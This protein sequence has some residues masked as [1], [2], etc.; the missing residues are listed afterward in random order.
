[1]KSTQPYLTFSITFQQ[2]IEEPVF[3]ILRTKE[4]LGYHVDCSARNTFGILGYTIKVECQATK[5]TTEYVDERIE[6]FLIHSQTLLEETTEDQLAQ[7][8]DDLIKIKEVA[9]YHL[10]EEVSRNW[11]EIITDDYMFDRNKQEI[12]AIRNVTLEEISDWWKRHNKFGNKES[13]RKISVQ[14]THICSKSK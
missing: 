12:E 14:V 6:E 10:Q 3:D 13:F 5:Y 2:I 1:M 7:I 11:E 4:Q 9:D 8:K